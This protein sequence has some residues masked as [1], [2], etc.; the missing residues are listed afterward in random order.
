ME[1]SRIF[2]EKGFKNTKVNDII[3]YLNIG[4]G[5][6]YSYF[7]NKEELFLECAPLIFEKFFSK[8]LEKIKKEKNPYRRL[9]M[10]IEI[11][12]PVIEE[13]N[14]IF[15]LSKESMKEMDP[16]L[17]NLGEEI[18]QSIRYPIEVDIANGMKQGIFRAVNPKIYSYMM[19]GVFEQIDDILIMNPDISKVAIKNVILD[20]IDRL[21]LSDR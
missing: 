20:V 5:S 14:V 10:R 19:L 2:Q 8:G 18:Y 7:S 4:K 13:F 17:K 3:N 11:T 12:M 16:N 6:F 9:I 21:L 15:K 1:G